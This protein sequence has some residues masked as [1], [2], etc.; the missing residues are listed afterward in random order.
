MLIVLSPAK[1]LDFETA[2]H[3]PSHT[4]PAFLKQSAQLIAA[5]R[6][7]DAQGVA[8]LMDLS[9]PLATLNVARYAAW[10][11]STAQKNRKQAIL[12]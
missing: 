3:V 10:S 7:F 12:A 9:E 2:P 11:L 1:S 6:E 8:K 5:L 4:R